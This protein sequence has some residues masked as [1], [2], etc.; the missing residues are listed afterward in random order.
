MK[1]TFVRLIVT[2]RWLT[3]RADSATM[4]TTF[5]VT[6]SLGDVTPEIENKHPP[7]QTKKTTG[8]GQTGSR[9]DL[10]IG[11]PDLFLVQ[12]PLRIG[13]EPM[14]GVPRPQETN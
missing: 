7:G 2:H 10:I 6:P 14:A 12:N 8:K 9:N 11:L 4:N 13:P 1:N 5:V 3:R